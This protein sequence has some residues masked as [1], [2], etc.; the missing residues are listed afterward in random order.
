MAIFTD[1]RSTTRSSMQ[2]VSTTAAINKT[3]Q[4]SEKEKN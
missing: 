2:L 4:K 3:K 1:E